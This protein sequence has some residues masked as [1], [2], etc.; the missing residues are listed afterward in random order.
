MALIKEMSE[1]VWNDQV[2]NEIAE[3]IQRERIRKDILMKNYYERNKWKTTGNTIAVCSTG[4]RVRMRH[5]ACAASVTKK[6]QH[7]LWSMA[8]TG[9]PTVATALS[10]QPTKRIEMKTNRLIEWE[11]IR[12]ARI[13]FSNGEQSYVHSNGFG[14]KTLVDYITENHDSNEIESIFVEYIF[15]V[16]STFK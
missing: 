12:G 4:E 7:G 13:E 8:S 11:A 16:F 5:K 9:E 10:Q 6:V 14:A 15:P 1:E 3:M 2:A